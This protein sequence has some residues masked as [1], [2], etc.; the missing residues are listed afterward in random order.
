LL[1][2]TWEHEESRVPNI[3]GF[4][5]WSIWNKRSSCRGI[6]GITCYI[7]KN[8]SPY[9][10]LHKKDPFNQY[11]W[12]E[13]LDINTKKIYLAIYYFVPINS[14]FYKKNNL[15]KNCPYNG[16]EHDIFS[17]RNEGNILLLGDFNARTTSNQAIILSNISNP[18]PLWLDEDLV[19]AHRYKRSSKDLGENLFGSKLIKL[20]SCQD[21]IICNDLMSW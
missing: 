13:I 8:L 21:L 7:R 17:L 9:I 19:L 3:E 15:D 6:G 20:C 14:T 18:N 5:L 16:L 1:V 10:R 12:M 11:I 2:E 4:V